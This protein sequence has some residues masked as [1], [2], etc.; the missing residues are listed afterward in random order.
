MLADP[1]AELRRP[2]VCD[3]CGPNSRAS[4][5][6]YFDAAGNFV[7]A[8]PNFPPALPYARF[9]HA[10]APPSSVSESAASEA[11]C[12]WPPPPEVR[13]SGAESVA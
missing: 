8:S 2:E 7:G 12:A 10:V 4:V 6:A 1:S 3:P 11:A 5:R 9:L 13:S